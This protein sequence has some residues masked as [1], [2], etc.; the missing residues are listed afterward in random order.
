MNQGSSNTENIRVLGIQTAFFWQGIDISQPLE[1]A[2]KISQYL[3]FALDGEP[4]VLPPPRNAPQVPVS[5][6]R[7]ILGSLDGRYKCNISAVRVD[8]VFAETTPELPGL[9]SAWEE[10]VKVVGAFVNYL[11]DNQPAAVVRLGAVYRLFRQL[12]ISANEF[13]R[14]RYL[15][16]GLFDLPSD[17]N[18]NLL[19]KAR[20]DR[21]D[22][23]RWLR[24]RSLRNKQDLENDRALMLEVD[25]N[26]VAE[27][28]HS[29]NL[30]EMERFFQT[31]YE[32]LVTEDIKYLLID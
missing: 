2:H 27:E 30:Y 28:Q 13:I 29:V 31:S 15:K 8:I 5:I 24:L 1:L 22:I 12:D 9:E 14:Q 19:H 18:I 10:Y 26:T 16:G 11:K 6:P 7:I 4:T 25:I 23:N 20:M 32:R 3:S 21:F 17:A